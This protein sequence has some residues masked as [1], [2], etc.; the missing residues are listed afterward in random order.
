[1]ADICQ[2][3]NKKIGLLGKLTSKTYAEGA[4]CGSCIKQFNDALYVYYQTID[5]YTLDQL[6]IVYPHIPELLP[7]KA[8]LEEIDAKYNNLIAPIKNMLH[9]RE[10]E[11]SKI[12]NESARKLQAQRLEFQKEVEKMNM[13]EG[14]DSNG[15]KVRYNA[16]EREMLREQKYYIRRGMKLEADNIDAIFARED[17]TYWTY[18]EGETEVLDKIEKSTNLIMEGAERQIEYLK[19]MIKLH[20]GMRV[21]ERFAYVFTFVPSEKD[22]FGFTGKNETLSKSLE[23]AVKIIRATFSDILGNQTQGFN[24][25]ELSYKQLALIQH[26][27]ADI[28]G[29][30][31]VEITRAEG[32]LESQS[33]YLEASEIFGNPE[34]VEPNREEYRLLTDNLKKCRANYNERRNRLQKKYISFLQNAFRVK[35]QPQNNVHA[36][37]KKAIPLPDV[38]VMIPEKVKSVDSTEKISTNSAKAVEKSSPER[39]CPSC[40]KG[41]KSTARF[42]NYC[43]ASLE[44]PRFCVQCGTK[45]RPGKKFCSGC[46]AKIE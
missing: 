20:E 22:L 36:V 25:S 13:E 46:G 35:N 34:H 4:I 21:C 9:Q 18:I 3:C 6:Q 45:L 30:F 41:N 37:E 24:L 12:E 27:Y 15:K 32:L 5:G 43:G 2:F 44:E 28:M 31:E 42:C 26:D 40:N 23:Y 38:Q 1:M 39:I 33:F 19:Q 11:Y 16:E 17:N 7:H 10:L 14:R 8:K 29:D